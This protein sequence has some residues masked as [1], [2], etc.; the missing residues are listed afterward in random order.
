[1]HNDVVS[2][3][4]KTR[5]VTGSPTVEHVAWLFAVYMRELGN[6]EAG[7]FDGVTTFDKTSCVVVTEYHGKK[8][9]GNVMYFGSADLKRLADRVSK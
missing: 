9:P 8:A 7:F 3:Y 6:G 1:M 5:T 4:P 2:Y